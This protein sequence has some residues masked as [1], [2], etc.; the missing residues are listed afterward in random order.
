MDDE[1]FEYEEE[2]LTWS[3]RF[4]RVDILVL[5]FSL[6]ADLVDAVGNNLRAAQGL[7]AAHANYKVDRDR[8]HEEAAL[9]IETLTA[10]EDDG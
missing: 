8:F 4:Q 2:S 10:G 3:R 9:E 6:A 5:G 1:E 7:L